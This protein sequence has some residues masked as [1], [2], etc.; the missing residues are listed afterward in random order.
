M[1]LAIARKEFLDAWRDGRFR[2]AAAVVVVL[3]GV[4]LLLASRQEQRALAEE[5]IRKYEHRLHEHY[6]YVRAMS[7]DSPEILNWRWRAQWPNS[8]RNTQ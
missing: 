7:I 4:A 6:D 5:L 8:A 3:L 2:I 1:I